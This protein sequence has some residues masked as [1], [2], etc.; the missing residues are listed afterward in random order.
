MDQWGVAPADATV[1]MA[2]KPYSDATDIAYERWVAQYLQGYNSWSDW[3]RAKAMG[4]D[5]KIALTVAPVR[6][7]GADIPQRHGYAAT[8]GSLNKTNYDAAVNAQGPDNLDTKL[9]LFK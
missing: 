7:N 8:A 2:T 6:I 5:T 1:Y 3:R 9:W 4:T